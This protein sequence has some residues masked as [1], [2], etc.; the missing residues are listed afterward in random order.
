MCIPRDREIYAVVRERMHEV[1]HANRLPPHAYIM[2]ARRVES[3][4]MTATVPVHTSLR[5]A[6]ADWASEL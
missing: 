5:R 4:V 3:T 2:F 1:N 6:V